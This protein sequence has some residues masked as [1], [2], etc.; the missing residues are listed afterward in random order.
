MYILKEKETWCG[1]KKRRDLFCY[2]APKFNTR[3]ILS[4]KTWTSLIYNLTQFLTRQLNYTFRTLII[5]QQKLIII[6]CKLAL[7]ILS[8]SIIISIVQI[9]KQFLFQKL[10]VHSIFVG[11]TCQLNSFV[12]NALAIKIISTLQNTQP[13]HKSRF[14]VTN[15]WFV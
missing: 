15:F 7:I 14:I 2:S 3:S 4:I 1:K 10:Y 13:L 6:V 5:L 8:I 12:I 9:C 11:G